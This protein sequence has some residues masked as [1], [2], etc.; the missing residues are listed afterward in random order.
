M[1]KSGRPEVFKLHH[2]DDIQERLNRGQQQKDIARDYGCSS[3]TV[4]RF[5]RRHHLQRDNT[6]LNCTRENERILQ[7]LALQ[8][9]G[10]HYF[11]LIEQG[12]RDAD[13][14]EL[15][16]RFNA[17]IADVLRAF[18][19]GY[20]RKGQEKEACIKTYFFKACKNAAQVYR[21]ELAD[22]LA[23][24]G[25]ASEYDIS[26][27]PAKFT[28]LCYDCRVEWRWSWFPKTVRRDRCPYCGSKNGRR[29]RKAR[30]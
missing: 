19:P 25:F 29:L 28:S 8:Y 12:F 7:R 1:S 18:V 16:S 17:K 22:A 9:A 3:K 26:K 15:E 27:A 23:E 21:Q 24:K 13:R 30:G 10:R 2:I 6:R 5:V 11:I 4:S 14:Q 20:R